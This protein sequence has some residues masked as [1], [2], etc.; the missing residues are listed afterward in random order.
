[1]FRVMPSSC[2]SSGGSGMPLGGSTGVFSEDDSVAGTGGNGS[3]VKALVGGSSAGI[4][5]KGLFGFVDTLSDFDGATLRGLWRWSSMRILGQ[6]RS[7]AVLLTADA[8]G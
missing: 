6:Y 3:S 2:E 7:L 4:E 8:R 1:M 5:I